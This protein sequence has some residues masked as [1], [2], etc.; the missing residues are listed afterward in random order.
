M[1]EIQ[2]KKNKP[3]P[4]FIII[5][6]QRG[7]TSSLFSYLSQH[8][9]I[10]MPV[11]KEVHF[12]DNNYEKGIDWYRNHFPV[13]DENSGIITGEAS[14]YYMFHPH[15]A[16]RVYNDTPKTRL[17]VLLR[18]PINRAYS[19]FMKQKRHQVETLSTFRESIEAEHTR[20]FDETKKIF[21]EPEY[22]SIN[23]QRLSYLSRGKY[24]SQ[25]TRWLKYFPFSQFLFIKSEDFYNDTLRELFRVHEFLGI[26]KEEPSNL[27]PQNKFEYNPIDE[28]TRI[29]LNK[30]YA[31]ENKKL[32]ELLG[33]NFCWE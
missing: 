33:D 11:T 20:L 31:E 27:S 4:D 7:G 30:Y 16:Q 13:I 26:N 29:D 24:Y 9:Q 15:A 28:E 2:S 32:C 21:N 5:G 6:T 14:P 18:N 22:K 1:C 17:I 23:H 25:L 19:H 10:R 3:L 12:F 8:S